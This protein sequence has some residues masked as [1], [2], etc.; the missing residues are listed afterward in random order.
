MIRI[1]INGFGRIAKCLFL[2]LNNNPEFKIVAINHYNLNLEELKLLIK[3]DTIYNNIDNNVKIKNNSLLVNGTKIRL[4]K[5]SKPNEIPW[6][7]YNVQYI[8]DTTGKFIDYNDLAGHLNTSIER[9]ILTSPS[10]T[11][12]MF[13]NGINT[14]LLKDNKIISASSCTSNCLIPILYILN[15]EYGIV[16]SFFTTVHAA[17]GSQKI[18]D[19]HNNK[20]LRLG[21]STLNNIIPTT[22]GATYS[23]TKLI[24]ELSNKIIGTSI[25][26]PVSGCSMVDLNITTDKSTS[27]DNIFEIIKKYSKTRFKNIISWVDDHCVSSDF[28]QNPHISIFDYKASLELNSNNFKLTLWYDNE[29]GYSNGVV[30]L[31]EKSIK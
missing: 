30:K 23:I 5:Y 6:N 19:S 20:K 9:I 21:R 18:V 28:I 3:Y 7:K 8:I 27:L 10:K 26:V 25:R 1:G 2:I 11:V 22:T 17:T 24:P 12:P 16:N 13:I 4:L 29:W 15:K 31:I 14:N